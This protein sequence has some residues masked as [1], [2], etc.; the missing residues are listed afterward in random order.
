M[1]APVEIFLLRKQPEVRIDH[2]KTNLSLQALKLL[3][4]MVDKGEDEYLRDDLIRVVYGTPQ[5]RDQFRRHA[6]FPLRKA[7]PPEVLEADRNDFVFLNQQQIQT[8]S[9]EFAESAN[10]LLNE[11]RVFGSQEIAVAMMVLDLYAEPFLLDFETRMGENSENARFIAWMRDRQQELASLKHQLL[12]RVTTYYLQ[13]HDWA[14]A[15]RSAEQW[16]RSRGASLKPVQILIWLALHQHSDRLG[17]YLQLL[18]DAETTGLVSIGRSSAEWEVIIRRNQAIPLE[19]LFF[20]ARPLGRTVQTTE[21]EFERKEIIDEVL[22]LMSSAREQ[23]VFGLVGLAGSGKTET[24]LAAV[25]YLLEGHPD[26]PVVQLELAAQIDLEV[27]V[28]NLLI[29]LQRADLLHLDYASKRQ[30]LKQLMQTP[31]LLVII[32][33]GHR[34]HLANADTLK[35]IL[36]VLVG[37][38]VMLVARQLPGFEVYEV[39]LPGFSEEQ[40]R[41]FLLAR[42]EW[43]QDV[44]AS[45][46]QELTRL[47]GGLPLMLNIIA[48]GLRSQRGR[49][50]SLLEKLR[51]TELTNEF[52]VFAQYKRVLDWLWQY[53]LTPEKNVLFGIS[54][55]APDEG[56][57][58]EALGLVVGNDGIGTVPISQRLDQLVEMRLVKRMNAITSEPRYVLHP[59]V[60]DFLRGQTSVQSLHGRRMRQGFVRYLIEYVQ[61]NHAQ[62]QRLDEYQQNIFQM[63]ELVLLNNE[64]PALQMRAVEALNQIYGY[65][66]QRGL[67]TKADVLCQHVLENVR[68]NAPTKIELLFNVGKLAKYRAQFDRALTFL[69]EAMTLAQETHVTHRNGALHFRIGEVQ[70]FLGQYKDALASYE[71]AVVWAQNDQND[72]LL[73]AVWSNIAVTYFYQGQFDLALNYYRDVERQLG[74]DLEALPVAMKA[75]AQHNQNALGLTLVEMGRY[76]EAKGYFY[77][78]LKL[79]RE[80]N[81]P[82]MMAYLY[83]NLGAANYWL[84]DYAEAQDCF[85]HGQNLAERIEH[86]RLRIDLTVAQA[87]LASVRFM[88]SDAFRLL[89]T[90]MIQAEDNHLPIQ[91]TRILVVAGKAYL[92]METYDSAQAQFQKVLRLPRPEMK[93]AA[94][95]LFGLI[96]GE[97][98]KTNLVGENRNRPALEVVRMLLDEPPASVVEVFSISAEQ[99]GSYLERV[100]IEFQQE[101]EQLPELRRFHIVEAL[102]EW[103]GTRVVAHVEESGATE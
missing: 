3:I 64:F 78:G 19:D 30:R 20:V 51:G 44:E 12:D 13:E 101:M 58:A 73:R 23:R 16:Q 84:K 90:A 28:N 47:T 21:A 97:L 66:E 92:R 82:E 67:Y 70:M 4:F 25:R 93:W 1:T 9:R 11:K 80:L 17:T 77:R 36:E 56:V 8:D 86:P 35:T 85:V 2:E 63:L 46:F 59:I 69:H 41:R 52:E 32:D 96:L 54:L 31:N 10:A 5:A 89:R 68:L 48:S 99:F 15:Q 61:A 55:F 60:L 94:Q 53:L 83:L 79:A 37:A 27:I 72:L 34:P 81:S 98:L 40:V 87:A 33:E 100:E 103:H 38:R 6:L 62:F 39:R 76:A 91:T 42:L 14:G 45:S 57:T 18:R 71:Q 29:D 24:A 7:L 43:L 75:I 88:H 26:H 74:D 102:K 65:F 50:P 95:A 22:K 49:L